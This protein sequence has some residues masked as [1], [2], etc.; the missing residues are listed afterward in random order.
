MPAIPGVPSWLE[1]LTVCDDHAA[2]PS[3]RQV[4]YGAGA[5]AAA[6][7]VLGRVPRAPRRLA[8]RSPARPTVL[9]GSLLAYSMAMHVHSSFSEQS[10]SMDS[11]F[12]QAATNGVDVLW[13]TDHDHRMDG[14]NY[15]KTVHFTSLTSEKGAPGQGGAW[16]WV[17]RKSGTVSSTSAGGIVTTPC[18]PNDPVAGGALSLTVQTRGRNTAKLGFYAN[19]QP[20]GWNYRDNL[21]GQSLSF[22][23]MLEPGWVNG[24]LELLIDTS[25][26]EASAGRAAGL[27]SLSYRIVPATGQPG[28]RVAQGN[29]GIITCPVTADGATW[30]TVTITPSDDIAALWPDLDY[31][32]FALWELFLNAA[33]TGDLV[34][35]YFDYLNFSRTI[36]GGEFF[37]Q[38]TDMISALSAE[39]AAVTA[40]QGLEVSRFLPHLNWFGGTVTVPTYQGVNASNYSAFLAGSVV[41]EVHSSGGLVS[42][43]HPFGYSDLPAYPQATQ[44]QMLVQTAGALLANSALGCDLLEVGYNLRQ[45]VDLAHHLSLWNVFSRNAF[46]LTGNGTTDDH[47]GT[48]WYGIRNNWITSAWA[49]S[50][51]TSDL[52]AALTAGQAWCGSLSEFGVG[53][54]LNLVVDGT[55]PMGSASLSSLPQRQLTV[56]ATGIPAGGSLLVLQGAV[57]YAGANGLADNTQVIA[58]YS[59]TDLAAAGGV[60]TLAADT[61]SESFATLRV[62]DAN[63]I[64]VAASNPV[65]MLQNTPP[66]GIPPPR[67]A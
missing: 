27:Y 62:T 23:V 57:D 28:T 22:D 42:Y 17:E 10:G 65:W 51:G 38:Q 39:Y 6:A 1:V 66:G 31:R 2:G 46:F 3:R 18:S 16:K 59:D 5:L 52:V 4:L 20:A 47:F 43:N 64:T 40:Q 21:T 30:T 41:P 53:A 37:S 24:Y 26:H 11:Q 54:S 12:Y 48:D 9:D 34:S 14:V 44:D 32:D 25:Y 56:S 8:L 33:S 61:S 50:T 55:C 19:C 60:E 29:Q 13:L 45:G 63:G 49:A 58:S 67:Q 36:S 15:R 35:G 7:V